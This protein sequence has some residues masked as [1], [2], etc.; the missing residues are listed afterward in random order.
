M[1]LN[2]IIILGYWRIYEY[3]IPP[4][5]F[6]FFF[7]SSIEMS[8]NEKK[9]SINDVLVFNCCEGLGRIP[10]STSVKKKEMSL[11]YFCLHGLMKDYIY[12]Q[13]SLL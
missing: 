9:K 6:F 12:I 7:L 8:E 1:I 2:I 4:C 10:Y 11:C 13:K 5:G 3:F